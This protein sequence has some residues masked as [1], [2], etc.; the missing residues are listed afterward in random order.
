[1]RYAATGKQNGDSPYWRENK[2]KKTIYVNTLNY[3]RQNPSTEYGTSIQAQNIMC[4]QGQLCYT[5]KHGNPL[6]N[7]DY[8]L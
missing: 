3:I 4:T 8:T 5:R 7:G 2:K 6:D 1:M